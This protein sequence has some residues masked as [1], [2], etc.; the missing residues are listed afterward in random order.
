MMFLQPFPTYNQRI[1]LKMANR[2]VSAMSR[3]ESDMV[4]KSRRALVDGREKDSIEK[5]RLMCLARGATGILGLGRTFRRMDDDGNKSLSREEFYKGLRD[6]GLDVN[7]EEGDDLFHKFDTDGNGSINMTEFLVALRP[8]M[9]EGRTNIIQQAF[10]KLD[11]TGDG[12]ITLDDLKNVYSV[13]AHPRYMSGEE[14]EESIMKKFLANFEVGGVVDGR[15]T[16]EEF[17]NY[18]ASVSA[19]I[20]NDAYFDLMMRQAYKL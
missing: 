18:Y 8:A 9:S 16:K 19:S 1:S 14:T 15:V 12:V 17:L 11:K 3:H 6:T 5:L 7:D 20:D 2:P 4:N 10:Q 13:K